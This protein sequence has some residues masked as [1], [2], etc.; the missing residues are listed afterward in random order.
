MRLRTLGMAALL[1]ALVA[2][3]G[4]PPTGIPA[5]F[6]DSKPHA[7]R[8]RMPIDYDIHGVDVSRYQ[9]D[10]DWAHAGRSGV[11]FAFIKATEGGDVADPMFQANWA[12]TRAARIPRGAYHFYY[13][14]RS[15]EEQ[16]AW[17]I[18]H[19]PRESGA[20]PPVLDMEWT[21]SRTCPVR[22]PAEWNR[23][24]AQRFLDILTAHYGQRPILYT[25]VDFFRDNEMWR[26]PNQEFWLRSVAGHPTEV[27]PGHDWGFWQY[28]GTGMA[29]GFRGAVD[30]N[31]FRGTPKDWQ[32]WLALRSQ[33]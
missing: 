20:L 15:P 33:W 27:Y 32:T 18:T 11:A 21:H 30:L 7:W 5:P 2:G 23:E 12:Q 31:T 8:G 28:T 4:G 1:A 22:R 14:C 9:G 25:T 26:I 16:A 17:F 24:Q 29:P 3:C 6:D 19:V 10:I 13:F